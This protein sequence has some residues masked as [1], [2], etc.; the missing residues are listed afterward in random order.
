MIYVAGKGTVSMVRSEK[1][2][3]INIRCGDILRIPSG[4]TVYLINRD[5]NEK[6]VIIKLLQP[7]FTPGF[8]EVIKFVSS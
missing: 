3:S 4:T 8:V 6:L 2:E 5:N 1:R 7:V